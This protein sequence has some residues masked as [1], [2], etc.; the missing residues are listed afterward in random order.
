MQPIEFITQYDACPLCHSPAINQEFFL[1]YK[2]TKIFYFS[3]QNCG[4]VFQNPRLDE[5]SIHAI[6]QSQE[7]WGEGGSSD[8]SAYSNYFQADHLRVRQSLSRLQKIMAVTGL[9]SGKLLDVGCATG[10][11]GFSAQKFGFEVI[12]IE[13][14]E[15]MSRFGR[16]QYGLKIHC[17]MLET[18]ALAETDFDIVTLWGTD[19]HFLHPWEGFKKLTGFLKPGGFIAMNYQNFHHW[20]RWFFPKLKKSPN[21]LFNLS[22]QSFDFIIN[23]LDL[24]LLYRGLEWQLVPLDHFFR[25]TKI[26]C[27]DFF[28][29]GS[30]LLPAISFPL[31]IA[32]KN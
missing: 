10:F 8:N 3:C 7:Y 31:V 2:A 16:E 17:C 15:Q 11:F 30:I 25:L 28:S 13:P 32:R 24:T 19:S 9:R 18:C 26:P 21:A 12:G 29:R 1:E 20:I 23:K 4:L 5:K 22:D 14:S 6:Y 27:P